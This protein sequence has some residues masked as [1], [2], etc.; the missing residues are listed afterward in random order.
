LLHSALSVRNDFSDAFEI[1][2]SI[3][4]QASASPGHKFPTSNC[5]KLTVA[6]L[7]RCQSS[8]GLAPGVLLAEIGPGTKGRRKILST[9]GFS[10]L[11]F[12]VAIALPLANFCIYSSH[13]EVI[14]VQSL[15]FYL[16]IDHR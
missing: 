11:L 2:T 12:A 15:R 1:R 7:A 13:V 8:P 14:G 4:S 16:Y 3:D 6:S 9:L 10:C 5:T